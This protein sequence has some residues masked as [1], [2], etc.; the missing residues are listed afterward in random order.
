MKRD[1]INVDPD[2]SGRILIATGNRY[3]NNKSANPEVQDKSDK[4]E[5]DK[6]QEQNRKGNNEKSKPA[7]SYKRKGNGNRMD[8][9]LNISKLSTMEMELFVLFCKRKRRVNHLRFRFKIHNR[10]R[11]STKRADEKD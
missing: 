11:L 5:N 3:S 4:K 9:R 10:G 8:Q 7:I 6:K 2:K 1:E